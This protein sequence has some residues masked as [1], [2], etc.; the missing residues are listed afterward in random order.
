MTGMW[1]RRPS[2]SRMPNGSATT[3]PTT[4][5]T[6]VSISP[7]QRFVST[8]SSP[9]PPWMRKKAMTGNTSR[10][11]SASHPLHGVF[12]QMS[13]ASSAARP[14]KVRLMRQY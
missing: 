11:K 4:A 8:T 6:R 7:P 1:E 14:A 12:G 5:S 10:V 9:A 2:A 13:R 3:M